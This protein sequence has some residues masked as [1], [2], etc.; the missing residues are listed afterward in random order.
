MKMSVNFAR[1]V[2]N[3]LRSHGVVVHEWTGW[4][5]RSNGQVS[6]YQGLLVHHTGTK[7]G[8]A[9]QGLIN[10]RSDLAGPLCNSAGNSDGSV[11]IVSAG[12]A[13]HAGASINSNGVKG[14]NLGPL[15]ATGSFNRYTWGHEIV[16]PGVSPMNSAQYRTMI[17]L[18]KVV[19]DILSRPNS[20]WVRGHGETSVTGKWDPGYVEGKMIDMYQVRRDINNYKRGDDDL[21][22]VEEVATATVNKLLAT[23]FN[24]VQLDEKGAVK[25]GVTVNVPFKTVHEWDDARTQ[26]VYALIRNLSAKVDALIAA[27]SAL[28]LDNDLTANEISKII[29]EAVRKNIQITGKVNITSVV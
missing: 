16:Y 20:E 17:I 26:S 10:G 15:P 3:G 28:S 8:A 2:I 21:P 14:K 22:S 11:T 1:A 7:L 24:L 23:Q 18:G 4:E 6:A 9:Y 5:G 19:S 25:P 27:V 12:P 29:E 13:N